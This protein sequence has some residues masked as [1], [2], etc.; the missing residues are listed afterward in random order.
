MAHVSDPGIRDHVIFIIDM[1]ES[2]PSLLTVIFACVNR[3]D[4]RIFKNH[5]RASEIDPTFLNILEP[6]FLT[7]RKHRQLY[8]QM[9]QQ[10]SKGLKRLVN[11]LERTRHPL[12][13]VA[14]ASAATALAKADQPRPYPPPPGRL[15]RFRCW[16]R[17]LIGQQLH[18]LLLLAEEP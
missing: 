18:V 11:P 2:T 6:L 14:A 4:N 15:Y 16:G 3:F 7:P 9:L 8:Q 17:A 1:P 13:S 5:N 10:S 12:P